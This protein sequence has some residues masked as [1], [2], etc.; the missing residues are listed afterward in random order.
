[1]A[2]ELAHPIIWLWCYPVSTFP[3]IQVFVLVSGAIV[4]FA[5][6]RGCEGNAL[7]M[8]KLDFNDESEKTLVNQVFLNAME[9]LADEDR[10][11]PQVS[12]GNLGG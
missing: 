7:Q 9:S 1:M 3:Y 8:S 6:R 2:W 5:V 10:Q 12:F 4:M 11:L